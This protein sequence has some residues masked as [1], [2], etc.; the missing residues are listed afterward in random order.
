MVTYI[1]YSK[2]TLPNRLHSL[3]TMYHISSL[4]HIKGAVEKDMSSDVGHITVLFC[5]SAAGMGVNF[6]SVQHVVHLGLPYST[7]SL[8]QQMGRAGRDGH[9]AFHLL[10]YSPVQRRY[11]D[12]EVLRY[13]DSR[14]CRRDALMDLH[15]GRDVPPPTP[16]L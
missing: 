9:Q 1:Q 8:L 5:T 6:S 4:D 2:R 13:I 14:Q 7:D 11:V 3:F 12:V 16:L 15:G 10:L